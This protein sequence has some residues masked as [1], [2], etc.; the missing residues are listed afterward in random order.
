MAKF[1]KTIAA[2]VIS[3]LALTSCGKSLL[4]EEAPTPEPQKGPVGYMPVGENLVDVIFDDGS[5][6]EAEYEFTLT[7]QDTIKVA[8]REP[9][10]AA[11]E[12][13]KQAAEELVFAYNYGISDTVKANIVVNYI[14]NDKSYQLC[15]LES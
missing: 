15:C 14:Y 2:I 5:K 4:I 3:A 1:L 10:K 9:I 11:E 12:L 8:G 13:S 6:V 7:A